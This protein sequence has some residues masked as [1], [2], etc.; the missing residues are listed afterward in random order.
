MNV[1]KERTSN[2][3]NIKKHIIMNYKRII[4]KYMSISIEMN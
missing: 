1:N 4:I 2:N 3:E